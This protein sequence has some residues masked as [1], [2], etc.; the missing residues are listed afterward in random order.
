[1]RISKSKQCTSP[2]YCVVL[3]VVF[4]FGA[5]VVPVPSTDKNI[6]TKLFD[7]KMDSME[8]I[9]M[10]RAIRARIN[11]GCMLSASRS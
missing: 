7:M 9:T 6:P 1:M 8:G 3:A 2:Y 11:A 5:A 4:L 10:H